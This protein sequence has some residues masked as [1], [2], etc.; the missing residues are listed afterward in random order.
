MLSHSEIELSEFL[1][2]EEIRQFFSVEQ[3]PY[4]EAL[5][6]DEFSIDKGICPIW[7][8]TCPTGLHFD[9]EKKQ[10]LKIYTTYLP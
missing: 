10:I 4:I 2:E 7:D 6:V 1:P 8:G 9:A 3:Y 5:T